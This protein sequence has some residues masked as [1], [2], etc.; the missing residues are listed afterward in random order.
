[1]LAAAVL[2]RVESNA[3]ARIVHKKR[4]CMHAIEE[5]VIVR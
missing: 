1:L 5:G 4:L 2:L 3:P